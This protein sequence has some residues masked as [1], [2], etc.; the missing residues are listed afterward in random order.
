MLGTVLA[1]VVLVAT[2][3]AQRV[4]KISSGWIKP[5]AVGADPATAYLTID[6]ATMYDVYITAAESDVAEV[7]EIRQASGADSRIV[8]EVAV[9]SFGQLAMTNEGVFLVLS[10]LKRALKAGET[11]TVTLVTDTGDR[12]TFA[13]DVK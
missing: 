3:S 6:N 10:K 9:P 2:P 5:P 4:V 13:A 8:S 7:V 1:A 12:L 11:V